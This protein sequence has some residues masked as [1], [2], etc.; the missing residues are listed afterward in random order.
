MKKIYARN[1]FFEKIGLEEAKK[2]IED[3]HRSGWAS[4][5]KNVKLYSL[6]FKN[7]TVAVA[8]FCNP[9]TSGMKKTYTTE[10]FRLA[11]RSDLRI[12]GGASK[13]IG[14]YIEE[15]KPWDIFTY[16]DTSGESTEVYEKSGMKLVSDAKTKKVLVKNGL[17]YSSAE[18]NHRDWFSMEQAVNRGPDALLGTSL[19]EVYKKD[20][21]RKS[22]IDLFIEHCGY[23]FEEIPGDRIYEWRN[24]NVYFY[25]YKITSKVDDYYYIGRHVILS[26]EFPSEEKCK[27]D[28]YWG[29]GSGLPQWLK[30]VGKNNLQKE[31]LSIHRTWKS[32]VK[33]E[34]E[35]VGDLYKTDPF[36]LNRTSGGEGSAPS[37]KKGRGN[38]EIHGEA[39]FLNAS[40]CIKCIASKSVSIR[41]CPHH[42]LTKY[43]G[44]KCYKCFSSS[45][46]SKKNCPVHGEVLHRGDTCC[47]CVSQKS[48]S[49][50]ICPIHGETK[51]SGDNCRS[52]MIESLISLKDCPVHGEVKHYGGSCC[53]CAANSAV[54]IRECPI[55]GEVKHQGEI[56]NSCLYDSVRY[57][58][59]CPK[60]GL[61]FFVKDSCLKCSMRK[62]YFN[63]VCEIHGETVFHKDNCVKCFNGRS[64]SEKVCPIHGLTS[65]QG[66]SCRACVNSRNVSEKEC[67][68]HG[69]VKF[70]GETC[71][72]CR[73]KGTVIGNCTTH[74]ET[75]FY[76]NGECCKCSS[77]K[78]LV[79]SKIC[80][81]C[82][83]VFQPTNNRQKYCTD[84]HYRDCSMCGNPF[85]WHPKKNDVCSMSCA[86]LLS[87]KR[88]TEA[89][90][91]T[92]L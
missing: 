9:R 37:V 57:Y 77:R 21:S 91:A 64:I 54:S 79:K 19:G 69:K 59:E 49:V 82:G 68:V 63:K 12:V 36:C 13:I 89:K 60:H 70:I 75:L 74:G 61:S 10:L 8:I 26:D 29:S 46:F 90:S 72:L 39:M 84:K 35:N 50:R 42:G 66:D 83:K 4:P 45:S 47:T 86:I 92:S 3:H 22:N 65:F 17:T 51:F 80:Q 18:N 14:N 6:K 55:H 53:S 62:A 31:I 11:F 73:K 76:R 56:C 78:K 16:Q 27:K 28:E 32:V 2:F 25:V 7:E 30:A 34:K 41:E 52:C 23:H 20:G 24:P 88:K 85:E 43:K 44:D 33:S 1:C 5:G 71:Y 15:E 40:A 87:N 81:E 48:I 58:R 67:P 38:C